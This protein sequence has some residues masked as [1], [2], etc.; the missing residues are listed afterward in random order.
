MPDLPAST[1]AVT[2]SV[3]ATNSPFVLQTATPSPSSWVTPFPNEAIFLQYGLYGGDGGNAFDDYHGRDTPKLIVYTNGMAIQRIDL[4][5]PW[6][7]LFVTSQLSEVE[8]CNLQRAIASPKLPE[9][10]PYAWVNYGHPLYNFDDT[11]TFFDGAPV[12]VYQL[13]GDPSLFL[14][15]EMAHFNYLISDV[16]EIIEF[17]ESYTL[18]DTTTYEPHTILL[19]IEEGRGLADENEIPEGWPVSLPSLESLYASRVEA[20]RRFRAS[21]VVLEGSLAQRVGSLFNDEMKGMLFSEDG[22]LF[23]TIMRPLL[24]HESPEDFSGFPGLMEPYKLPF[25]CAT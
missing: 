12:D 5:S 25:E 7:Y 24:P 23:Y 18:T 20:P 22:R 14:S 19:W 4:I 8:L 16:K 9:F 10:D 13:N 11:A 3:V 15:I 17:V 6:S 21:H 1:L 2:S